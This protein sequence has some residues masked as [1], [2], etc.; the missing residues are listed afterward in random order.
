MNN[1]SLE[2]RVSEAKTVIENYYN[3]DQKINICAFSMGGYVAIKITQL[4][5]VGNLF[6]FCPAVYD[7]KAYKVNFGENFSKII[8]KENSWKNSD[9]WQILR[10]YKNNL[11]LWVPEKDEIVP[12]EISNLIY[13]NTKNCKSKKM[14]IL[15]EFTHGVHSWIP[16]KRKI[17]HE[18]IKEMAE[19]L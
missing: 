15:P 14:T 18:I 13:L 2:K 10:K 8:R 17:R 12:R 9:A 4:L 1:S 11:L 3:K 7:K 19:S 6:L 5:N 16:R